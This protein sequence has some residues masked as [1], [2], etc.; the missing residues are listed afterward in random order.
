[1]SSTR[2]SNAIRDGRRFAM[3]THRRRVWSL[4][5]NNEAAAEVKAP[6]AV[7]AEAAELPMPL[8]CRPR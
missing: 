8:S 4:H 2:A 1:M 6:A 7:E 5:E 3:S